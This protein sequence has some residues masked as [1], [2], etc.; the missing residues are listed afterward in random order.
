ML[1]GR[2]DHHHPFDRSVFE[3]VG[4]PIG[5][6]HIGVRG[7][8]L[9]SGRLTALDDRMQAPERGHVSNDVAA[10]ITGSHDGDICARLSSLG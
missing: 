4:Q 2:D 9:L 8:K 6:P 7:P 10:P 3:G 5:H 1:R